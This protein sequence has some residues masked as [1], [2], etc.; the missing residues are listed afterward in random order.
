MSTKIKHIGQKRV[1][2]S[3]SDMGQIV[4]GLW[5]AYWKAKDNGFNAIADNYY[6]MIKTY[7]NKLYTNGYWGEDGYHG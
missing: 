1:H 2:V 6:R 3:S 4:V 7:A 5:D